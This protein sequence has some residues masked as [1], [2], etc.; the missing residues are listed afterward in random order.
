MVHNDH[1]RQESSC[2]IAPPLQGHGINRKI[3]ISA[4]A[5][6]LSTPYI[7][8]EVFRRAAPMKKIASIIKVKKAREARL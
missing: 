5:T 3:A 1:G 7:F 8:G 6:R 4:A 2:G